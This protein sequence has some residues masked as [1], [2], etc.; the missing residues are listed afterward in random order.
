M[1]SDSAE[2]LHKKYAHGL[3]GRLLEGYLSRKDA[4]T[5]ST[6]VF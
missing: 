5:Q 3:C 6:A 2:R 4:E 1:I